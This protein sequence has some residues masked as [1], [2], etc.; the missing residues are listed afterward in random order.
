MSYRFVRVEKVEDARDEII[1]E[2]NYLNSNGDLDYAVYCELFNTIERELTFFYHRTPES[3]HRSGGVQMNG[4][5]MKKDEFTARM[6]ADQELRR[7]RKKYVLVG[8]LKERNDRHLHRQHIKYKR[9][10][11]H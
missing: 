3:R 1:R 7:E 10:G 9:G 5:V 4:R 6:L 2:L 11:N 8:Y